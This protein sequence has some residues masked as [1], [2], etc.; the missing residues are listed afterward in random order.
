MYFITFETATGNL[1]W[2]TDRESK[3]DIEGLSVITSEKE[4]DL[5]LHKVVDGQLVKLATP[6][7]PPITEEPWMDL[8]KARLEELNT[9]RLSPILIVDLEELDNYTLALR[10]YIAAEDKQGLALPSKPKWVL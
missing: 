1:R 4:I 10:D 5:D 6:E 2:I 7:S 8:V 3:N 9:Y